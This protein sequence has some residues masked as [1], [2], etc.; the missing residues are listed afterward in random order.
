M[1]S[2]ILQ[3]DGNDDL[4]DDSSEENS[5]QMDPFLDENVTPNVPEKPAKAGIKKNMPKKKSH[6][7]GL[8]YSKGKGKSKSKAEYMRMKRYE[9]LRNLFEK[10][11][12]KL[13]LAN[14]RNSFSLFCSH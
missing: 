2:P 6:G 7:S 13:F 14:I 12:F 11:E 4:S 8:S 1:F 10:K 9:K 5:P 3:L